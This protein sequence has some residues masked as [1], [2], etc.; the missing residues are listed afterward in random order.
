MDA[1]AALGLAG[2]TLASYF[3]IMNP[4]SSTPVFISLT[5]GDDAVTKRL[6]A[7]RSLAAH[8]ALGREPPAGQPPTAIVIARAVSTLAR[9]S[10]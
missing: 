10:R 1:T 7:V 3:A 4:I 9:C 8:V 2:T 6:V 5:E